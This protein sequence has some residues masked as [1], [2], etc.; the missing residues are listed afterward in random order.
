M[1]RTMLQRKTMREGKKPARLNIV[2]DGSQWFREGPALSPLN[3]DIS[4]DFKVLDASLLK[5][6]SDHAGTLAE[7]G[8]RHLVASAFVPPPD[9]DTWTV[10]DRA[11]FESEHTKRSIG[12]RNRFVQAALDAGYSGDAVY[13]IP[14]RN[15]ML[16][17]STYRE[18]YVGMTVS[19]LLARS[20]TRSPDDYHCV[21]TGNADILAAVT[22]ACPRSTKTLF[23]AAIHR[24]VLFDVRHRA[25]FAPANFNL[26][27]PPF[28]LA[29]HF[30]NLARGGQVL[31]EGYVYR[32]SRCHEKFI[33]RRPIRSKAPLLCGSCSFKR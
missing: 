5:H 32:C 28:F 10:R 4:V 27:I 13:R 11:L 22:V 17:R 26:R 3:H 7:L 18:D 30:P 6:V 8:E 19:A 23:I 1:S 15:W 33:R 20:I 12:A 14:L 31:R 2:V 9:L 16:R 24:E 29:D 21:L 25:M